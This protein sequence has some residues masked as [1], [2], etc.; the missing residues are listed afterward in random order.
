MVHTPVKMLERVEPPG[1]VGTHCIL[2][3]YGCPAESLNDAPYILKSLREAALEAGATFL[4]ETFH[5]FEPHGVTALTL[6][7]ESHISIHTWP[8]SG[9]AAVDVFTCGDHTMPETACRYL[10]QALGSSQYTLHSLRRQPPA[11]VSETAR[12]PQALVA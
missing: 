9:Y 3:L 4:K 12:T 8:E 10:T 6:L 11:T 1:P 7:A 2:E 5:C